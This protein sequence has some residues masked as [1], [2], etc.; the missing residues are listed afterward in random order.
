MPGYAR[1]ICLTLLLLAGALDLSW[2]ERVG[3]VEISGNELISTKD[4]LGIL[5]W[6]EGGEWSVS[7]EST[8]VQELL[9]NYAE[10]GY[11]EA[12]GTVKTFALDDGLLRIELLVR[13]GEFLPLRKLDVTGATLLSAVEVR[14]R[15]DSAPGGVLDPK[16]LERDVDDLLQ[17]YARRGHPFCRLLLTGVT[18]ESDPRGFGFSFLLVEGPFLELGDISATGND[19]TR[20][21]TIRRLS[22]LHFDEPYDQISVDESRE[23]LLHSGLFLSVSEPATRVEWKDKVAI[24][25]FELEEARTNRIEGLF[26]Y[27][28]GE[29]DNNGVLSGFVNLSFRNIMG[30][31]RRAEMHWEQSAPGSRQVRLAY[32]EPWLFGS[33]FAVGG[34][35]E[36]TLRDSSWSRSSGSLE[37]DVAAGRRITTRFTVG[38]ESM[39]TSKVS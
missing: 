34:S 5:G 16:R 1:Q 38:T 32:R 27:A 23:R 15:F 31:A 12:G 9:R 29:G 37:I 11:L 4:A 18:D 26:G 7:I 10:S 6:D 2:A 28:P 22:G 3:R 36:Q 35:A 24:V 39:T 30:T 17:W 8:G 21:P 20:L 13:E 19:V 33:P 25:E 14:E